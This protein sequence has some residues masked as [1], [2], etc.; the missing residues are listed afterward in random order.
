MKLFSLLILSLLISVSVKATSF[1]QDSVGLEVKDGKWVVVHKVDPGETLFSISQRYDAEIDAI[2]TMNDI[3]DYSITEGALLYV[4]YP[5]AGKERI[6]SVEAGDTMFSLSQ[7][8]DVSVSELMKWNGLD[9]YQLAVGQEISVYL[10]P[11]EDSPPVAASSREGYH[12][13]QQGETLY[14]IS[15][16]HNINVDELK[17]WNDLDNNALS[18]GQELIISASVA[19]I[20]TAAVVAQSTQTDPEP[21]PSQPE[22]PIVADDTTISDE[23]PL[24]PSQQKVAPAPFTMPDNPKLDQL[25]QIKEAGM[26]E[27]IEGTSDNEKFLALHKSAEPGT[28]LSVTNELNHQSVFVRVVGQIPNTSENERI[29]VKLSKAAYDQLDAVNPKFRVVVSRLR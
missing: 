15:Q 5:K 2:I 19:G 26:A 28:I 6:Y 1:E 16:Q 20:A 25:D 21:S 3:V 29:V 18:E 9:S 14:S 4:P 23:Y 10:P 22:Q 13:V 12:I 7:K 17:R 27:L 11:G 24:D 8:F